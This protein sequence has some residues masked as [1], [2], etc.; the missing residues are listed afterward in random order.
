VVERE[1]ELA[2]KLCCAKGTKPAEL[3]ASEERELTMK[4]I[5]ESLEEAARLHAAH[6]ARMRGALDD[7]PEG[8]EIKQNRKTWRKQTIAGDVFWTDG[9]KFLASG[10]LYLQVGSKLLEA[11]IKHDVLWGTGSS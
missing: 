8:Y 10:Q 5:V 6:L 9:K 1:V 3:E 7:L 11:H 2:R 4:R